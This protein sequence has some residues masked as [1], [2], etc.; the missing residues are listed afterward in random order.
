MEKSGWKGG[1]PSKKE[2][3]EDMK[4]TKEDAVMDCIDILKEWEKCLTPKVR[5]KLRA[6]IRKLEAYLQEMADEERSKTARGA[7]EELTAKLARVGRRNTNAGWTED[8]MLRIFLGYRGDGWPDDEDVI[9]ANEACL[10]EKV[11]SDSNCRE[12]PTSPILPNQTVNVLC[13]AMRGQ[14]PEVPDYYHVP[15]TGKAVI[16]TVGVWSR[17]AAVVLETRVIFKGKRCKLRGV[18]TGLDGTVL[19]LLIDA[20]YTK[21]GQFVAWDLYT[22]V[23]TDEG[24]E[25]GIAPVPETQS[26]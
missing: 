2:M 24:R 12:A 20:P 14:K 10:A 23:P 8:M 16:E 19:V 5:N 4:P 15:I 22:D 9:K 18:R 6:A 11:S 3:E 26:F 25:H 21:A 13:V 17:N 7:L 1:S